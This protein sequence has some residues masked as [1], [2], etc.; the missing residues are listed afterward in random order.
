[1]EPRTVAIRLLLRSA[2][3]RIV[4]FL[5]AITATTWPP[6]RGGIATV[7]CSFRPAP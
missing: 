4:E 6:P 1:M 5:P 3:D 2:A 7:A